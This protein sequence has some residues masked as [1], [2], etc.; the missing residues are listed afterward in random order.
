[1]EWSDWPKS[2]MAFRE[3]QSDRLMAIL[4]YRI[5]HVD[6]YI[7]AALEASSHS[8]LQSLKFRAELSGDPGGP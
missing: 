5:V 7:S 6:T 2:L 8:N 1:M 3:V 4:C